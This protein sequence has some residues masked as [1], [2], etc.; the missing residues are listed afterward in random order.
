MHTRI[1]C[2]LLAA[3]TLGAQTS[4]PAA[5][6]N[7]VG[8]DVRMLWR[9]SADYLAQSAAAMPESSYA[10]RPTAS[11]R[12]FG[13]LIGHVA[14]SQY[15]FCATAMGV[16]APAEDE[17]E[18]TRTTK[19][20]LIEALTQSTAY[21]EKAYAQAD[22]AAGATVD[23]FGS[24]GTKRY[25]LMLNATHN[26]E[27]YGNVVTYLRMNGLVPPSSQRGQ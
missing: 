10:F 7:A 27:H 5:A 14:G 4:K 13:Q 11:V 18:K 8:N 1:V 20:A 2:L 24:P 23:V 17:I 12:T 19:G 26:F 21:C 25:A 6:K 22:A 15:T 9:Q 3:S 16:K